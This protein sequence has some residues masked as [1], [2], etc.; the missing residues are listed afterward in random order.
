MAT[1]LQLPNVLNAPQCCPAGLA[2]PMNRESAE[3]LA[4]ILKAVADPARLQLLALLRSAVD[5]EACV[6]DLTEP[7]GLTQPTVSHHLKVL[8]EAGLVRRER[9]GTWAWYSLVPDRIA[10]ISAV[11]CS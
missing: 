10:E 2:E 3:S 6:C 7:L 9:R 11:F 4:Q 1:K 5:G 8:V